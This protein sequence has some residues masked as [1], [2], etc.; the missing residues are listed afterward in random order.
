MVTLATVQ[1]DTVLVV[2]V[3][4]GNGSTFRICLPPL[5]CACKGAVLFVTVQVGNGTYTVPS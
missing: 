1:K 4:V 3:Q 2:T 5:F